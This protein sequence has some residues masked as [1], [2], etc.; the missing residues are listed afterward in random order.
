VLW[1]RPGQRAGASSAPLR[2]AHP[3][4]QGRRAVRVLKR[5][6]AE[7]AQPILLDLAHAPGAPLYPL[8]DGM[9]GM[10]RGASPSAAIRGSRR[11]HRKAS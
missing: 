6:G 9:P 5:R 8:P 3:P 1:R 4:A 7:L 2:L 11:A 10:R